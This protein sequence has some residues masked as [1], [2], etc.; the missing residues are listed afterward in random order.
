MTP[1]EHAQRLIDA[2]NSL[3]DVI[4]RENDALRQSRLSD[5]AALHGAKQTATEI[6]ETRLR[7]AHARS[8][9]FGALSPAL[10]HALRQCQQRF[11]NSAKQNINTL[12]AAMELN[13]RLVG[14]IADSIEQQ[15]INPAGYTRSGALAAGPA[16]SNP[17]DAMPVS[18]DESH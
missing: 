15:R 16:A 8:E 2:A 7:D 12:R 18:L 4:E 13:R 10:G 11:D 6:Y 1:T 17:T 5:L 14:K 3:S 9:D